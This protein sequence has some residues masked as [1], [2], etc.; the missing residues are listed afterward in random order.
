M[1][2]TIKSRTFGRLLPQEFTVGFPEPQTEIAVWL[3]GKEAPIDVTYRYSV[4]C[5][6]PLTFCIGFDESVR[7]RNTDRFCLKFCRRIEQRTLG[8]IELHRVATLSVGESQFVFFEPCRSTNYCLPRTQLALHYL[9]FAYRDWRKDNTKGV[10]LSFLEK[11][12]MMVEFIRPHPVIL[13]SVG[14]IEEGNI[15][16]MNLFGD[17]GNGYLG[18]A[19]RSARLAGG[20]VE[21][22][23]RIAI[24]SMPLSQGAVAYQLAHNHSKES[25]S[26][27]QLPYE[28]RMSAA[29][30]I[31]VPAFALRVREM[32]IQSVRTLGSHRFFL[33]RTVREEKWSEG[34]AFCSIHG[35]YESWRLKGCSEQERRDS[36]AGDAF[37]K[38][39]RY[40]PLSEAP[41][42]ILGSRTPP[43]SPFAP[44]PPPKP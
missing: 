28:I 35:F 34:L 38:R 31:P 11:R 40:V 24:S 2:A 26:W 32:E 20:L 33:A 1:L 5:A 39:G 29:F 3:H 13:V 23:G 27:A 19:L 8:A 42:E 36:L 30:N 15:F 4:A 14:S 44:C 25:F 12:A 6:A 17:L 16:P 10:H 9:L 22:R 43:G 18:L 41:R 7:Y 21:R 37:S